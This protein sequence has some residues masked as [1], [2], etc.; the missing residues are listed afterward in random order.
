MILG[1]VGRSR[2]SGTVSGGMR[3]NVVAGDE[4]KVTGN[5]VERGCLG[6]LCRR[7]LLLSK[8]TGVGRAR[9]STSQQ[10]G[11]IEGWGRAAQGATKAAR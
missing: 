4:L 9:E 10:S 7:R 8:E 5:I 6:F 3:R 11:R 1:S 2:D